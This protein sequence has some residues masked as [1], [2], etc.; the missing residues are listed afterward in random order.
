[1]RLGGF[2]GSGGELCWHCVYSSAMA[3]S[4][5]DFELYAILTSKA[6]QVLADSSDPYWI[7][8]DAQGEI[9]ASDLLVTA[10]HGGVAYHLWAELTDIAS[11]PQ[12]AN[13]ALCEERSRMAAGEWLELDLARPETIERYFRRWEDPMEPVD[14]Q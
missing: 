9:V 4:D 8:I 6:H 13:R 11:H 2:P 12:I 10:D 14:A 1:M 3:S 5:A 7:G